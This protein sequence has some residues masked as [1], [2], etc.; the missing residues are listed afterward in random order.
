MDP[1]LSRETSTRFAALLPVSPTSTWPACW[2]TSKDVLPATRTP[3]RAWASVLNRP[4]FP[5]AWFVTQTPESSR[6]TSAVASPSYSTAA[7]ATPAVSVSTTVVETVV[8]RSVRSR[9]N[10]PKTPP[11]A[12]IDDDPAAHA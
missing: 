11:G 3:S 12:S 6:S 9:A 8:R 1:N 4:I 5:E 7:T 2:S 10:R